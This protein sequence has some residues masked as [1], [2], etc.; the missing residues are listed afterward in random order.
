MPDVKVIRVLIKGCIPN[1]K[2]PLSRSLAKQVYSNLDEYDIIYLDFISIEIMSPSFGDEIFRVFQN[3]NP[4]IIL[5]PMNIN[6]DVF[7]VYRHTL[8][9]KIEL[10]K[11]M[12]LFP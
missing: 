10:D 8:Y 6:D 12:G 5:I 2:Q 3:R 9:R 4:S 11:Q 7:K 1:L